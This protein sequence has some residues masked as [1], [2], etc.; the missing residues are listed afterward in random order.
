MITLELR[1]VTFS[2]V[3]SETDVDLAEGF[4]NTMSD[5]TKPQNVEG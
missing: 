3:G 5:F 2:A 4:N 1:S